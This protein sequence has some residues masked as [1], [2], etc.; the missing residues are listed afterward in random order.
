MIKTGKPKEE[1]ATVMNILGVDKEEAELIIAIEKGEL[2]GDVE[3][4]AA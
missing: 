4:I 1:I 3:E 2:D